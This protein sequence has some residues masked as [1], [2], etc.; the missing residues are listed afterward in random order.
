MHNTIIQNNYNEKNLINKVSVQPASVRLFNYR[1]LETTTVRRRY[2]TTKSSRRGACKRYWR[3]LQ[4]ARHDGHIGQTCTAN[5]W[6]TAVRLVTGRDGKLQNVQTA[7]HQGGLRRR[8]VCR[9]C[10]GP[11][12][13]R[14][15]Q[16]SMLQPTCAVRVLIRLFWPLLTGSCGLLPLELRRDQCDCLTGQRTDHCCDN[17]ASDNAELSACSLDLQ[18]DSL[19]DHLSTPT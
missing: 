19:T 6:E 1:K 5:H 7:H 11:P 12:T 14:C 16:R 13:K 17:G 15:P 4:R 9:R 3:G 2:G 18:L 8:L 10:G